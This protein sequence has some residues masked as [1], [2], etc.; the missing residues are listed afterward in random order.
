MAT[1]CEPTTLSWLNLP[2]QG[3]GLDEARNLE[4]TDLW[5]SWLGELKFFLS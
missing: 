4:D 3:L 2:P 1:P 5:E